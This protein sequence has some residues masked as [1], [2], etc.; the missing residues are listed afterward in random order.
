MTQLTCLKAMSRI[1]GH[2]IV[3]G[4]REDPLILVDGLGPLLL[5]GELICIRE[6]AGGAR[7]FAG[8]ADAR[9]GF[10]GGGRSEPK[11][12]Q[13]GRQETTNH[14]HRLPGGSTTAPL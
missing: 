13:G 4:F 11:P 12:E 7:L 6:P 10:V 14:A 9:E 5:G 2:E 1:Q 8:Q 3:A